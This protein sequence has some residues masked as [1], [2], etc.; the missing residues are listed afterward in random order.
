MGW[1]SNVF[2]GLSFRGCYW[3]LSALKISGL[4]LCPTFNKNTHSDVQICRIAVILRATQCKVLL[5]LQF[6]WDGFRDVQGINGNANWDSFQILEEVR[7]IW[8][9]RIGSYHLYQWFINE[10]CSTVSL[11]PMPIAFY[12]VCS[13]TKSS[14]Q[15]HVYLSCLVSFVLLP[16]IGFE[17]FLLQF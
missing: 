10:R 6:F 5:L 17:S 2:S 12:I 4:L 8:Q 15:P 16:H 9:L 7:F 14:L 11:L 1:S 13:T 3:V